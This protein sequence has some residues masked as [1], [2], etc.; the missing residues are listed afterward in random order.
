MKRVLITGASGYIGKALTEKA[1]KSGCIV[2]CLDVDFGG[3]SFEGV[4]KLHSIDLTDKE[5]V[6]VLFQMY[7][8][9]VVFHLAAI[10]GITDS[11]SSPFDAIQVNILGTATILEA[12]R[13]HAPNT[14]LI[15]ASTVYVHSK[16]GSIY[17]ATKK[18]CELL[19]E[20]YAEEYNVNY[21]FLRF[22]SVYGP[23][24]NDFNFVHNTLRKAIVGEKLIYD[25][26]GDEVR[27]YIHINDAATLAFRVI[28][29]EFY[30]DA[31]MITGSQK[32]RIRDLFDLI[33]EIM[34]TKFDYVFKSGVWD[35]HYNRT[36]YSYDPKIS[37]RLVPST[38]IDLAGGIF[39]SLKSIEDENTKS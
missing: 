21:T 25:G 37:K 18:C 13:L 32:I 16:H 26:T 2:H 6:V 35:G 11:K 23:G 29:S 19:I 34:N 12:I 15:Y 36:P 1:V 31:Y 3:R 30:G 5:A 28:G 9:D 8:F 7:D 17:A 27:E 14:Q 20:K 39:E 4:Q 33:S 22:G 24:A 10:A 38:E